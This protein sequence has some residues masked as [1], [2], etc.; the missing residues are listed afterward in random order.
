MEIKLYTTH[1]PCCAVLEKKLNA[2]NIKY[3]EISDRE[4]IEQKGITDVPVL[5]IDGVLYDFEQANTWVNAQ[6]G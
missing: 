5:E 6:G 1:C 3:C 4:K 2:K